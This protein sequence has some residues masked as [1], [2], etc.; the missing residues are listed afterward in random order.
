[1]R[2]LTANNRIE[3]KDCCDVV[4]QLLKVALGNDAH[5]G[6]AS[7]LVDWRNVINLASR[8]GILGVCF[9]AFNRIPE[10][11]R[12]DG[13][14]L[15]KWIGQA[16]LMEDRYKQYQETLIRLSEIVRN[17]DI[18]M[19][20]LKGYGCSLNYPQPKY[21]PCGDIDIFLIDV[22]G[23]HT[24]LLS[25]RLEAY[26][27]KSLGINVNN[28]NGHHSQ[29]LFNHFLV[30]NHSTVLDTDAHKSSL[31]LNDLLVSMTSS[32]ES[33]VVGDSE[34]WLP[35]AK[36]NSVHLLRHMASDFASV[37]T[38]IRN[39]LDWSTFVSMN[40]VDWTFV[41][42]VAHQANMHRFLDAINGICVNY[43][44]YPKEKFPVESSDERLG[45]KVLNEIL[46]CPDTPDFPSLNSSL[47]NKISY[48]LYKTRRMWKNRWK[49]Q[50]V[51]DE[52]LFESF[53]WK[54][55]S[56]LKVV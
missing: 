54:V 28:Q 23:N 19:L 8:Q 52:S 56:R 10:S 13:S 42:E 21:R 7:E 24:D 35:S 3:V 34:V 41:H 48:D 46:S 53:L 11:A 12:P 27:E 9:D 16:L 6:Y 37:R 51:Y 31:Y 15:I 36:F 55:R 47:R 25:Q 38:S 40:N 5:V 20:V 29:F 32:S 44:G 39:L 49:Y 26:L 50:I 17:L 4:F 14:L 1:M 43:L 2:S 30:E 22:N 33:V 18:R 45:Q